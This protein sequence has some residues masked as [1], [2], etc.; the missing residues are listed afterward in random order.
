M[1][2]DR[3]VPQIHTANIMT[4]LRQPI[5]LDSLK[6]SQ[7]QNVV[8]LGMEVLKCFEDK[9]SDQ[10]IRELLEKMESDVTVLEDRNIQCACNDFIELCNEYSGSEVLQPPIRMSDLYNSLNELVY[11]GRL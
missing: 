7:V 11:L 9:A 4:L 6:N 8:L 1:S 2:V 10:R 5:N 3:V